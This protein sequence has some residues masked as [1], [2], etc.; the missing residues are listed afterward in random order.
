M[1][2]RS[3][4]DKSEAEKCIGWIDVSTAELLVEHMSIR[5]HLALALLIQ[6]KAFFFIIN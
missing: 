4:Y 3:E 6:K 1:G 2:E 5:D